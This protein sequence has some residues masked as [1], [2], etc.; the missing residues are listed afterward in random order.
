MTLLHGGGG[1]GGGGGVLKERCKK[2][3][4]RPDDAH[5]P[6]EHRPHGGTDSHSG[7]IPRETDEQSR[8]AEYYEATSNEM[9]LLCFY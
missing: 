6:R 9:D 1:G 2:G 5:R 8:N 7:E 4:T 3:D